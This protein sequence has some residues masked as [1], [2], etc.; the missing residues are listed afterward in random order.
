MD[1]EDTDTPQNPDAKSQASPPLKPDS[2]PAAADFDPA[3][4]ATEEDEEAGL[5]EMAA[6]STL[7]SGK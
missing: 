6:L 5:P 3:T 2:Q 4:A 1:S 7:S